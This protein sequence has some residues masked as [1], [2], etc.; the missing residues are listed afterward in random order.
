MNE[1]YTTICIISDSSAFDF[2]SI[3]HWINS[4]TI[5]KVWCQTLYKYFQKLA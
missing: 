5:Y 3:L 2:H 4:N 1:L